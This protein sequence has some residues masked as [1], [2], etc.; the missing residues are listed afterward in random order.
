MTRSRRG[1]DADIITGYRSE[2]RFALGAEPAPVANRR[3][4]QPPGAFVET[5]NLPGSAAFG[6]ES[7]C[8]AGLRFRTLIPFVYHSYFTFL[9]ANRI[10]SVGH[11]PSNVKNS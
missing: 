8:A 11:P 7:S 2:A 4:C 9:C 6:A 3:P 1:E 5:T 10:G